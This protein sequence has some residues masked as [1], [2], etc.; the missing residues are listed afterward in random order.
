MDLTGQWADTLLAL[1]RL[2]LLK[3]TVWGALS[4]VVGTALIAVL[5]VRRL[6]SPLLGRFGLVTAAWGLAT[7]ATA[8]WSRGA[9]ALRDLGGAVSLDRWLWFNIGLDA[10]FVLVGATLVLCGWKLGP[11]LAPHLGV[12]GAG[13]GIVVQALALGVLGLQLTADIVR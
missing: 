3:L 11:R 6:D 7:I 1:E 12:V 4:V 5:Q 9:L 2:Y 13:L 8:L 10:G